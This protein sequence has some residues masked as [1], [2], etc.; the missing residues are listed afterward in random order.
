MDRVQKLLLNLIKEVSSEP[1]FTLDIVKQ[2]I[3]WLNDIVGTYVIDNRYNNLL[4]KL[5]IMIDYKHANYLKN[6]IY[7]KL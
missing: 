6:C 2:Y 7:S 5:K 3:I 1:L 4:D